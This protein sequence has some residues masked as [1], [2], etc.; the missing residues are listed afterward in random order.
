MQQPDLKA[1]MQL[2]NSPSGQQLIAYLKTE[3]STAAKAAA[4][5][6]NAGDMAAARETLAPLLNDPR[7]REILEQLGGKP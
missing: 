1:L 6:A 2:L 7:F 4:A 3:G 5:Q